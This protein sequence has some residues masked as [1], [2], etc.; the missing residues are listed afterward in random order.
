MVRRALGSLPPTAL[1]SARQQLHQ[2]AQVL[3]AAG[4]SYLP[5]LPDTSHTAM[6]W[7]TG[8][9]ALV[10]FPLPG[11]R[12]CRIALRAADLTLLLLDEGGRARAELALPGR[13]RAE[14]EAWTSAQVKAHS[15]GELDRSLVHPGF[16]LEPHPL[17]QGGR[18]RIEAGLAEL[19]LWYSAADEELDRIARS[20]PGAGPVL[21]WPHHFDLATLI[22]VERDAGGDALRTIGVGLSPG[23]D[24]FDEPYWYVNHDPSAEA[25]ALPPLPAGGWTT[26]YWVGAVLRGSELVAAGGAE[27]QAQR[28]RD[29]LDAAL[30]ASQALVRQAPLE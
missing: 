7:D 2:A 25:D 5:P 3:A 19:A 9:G 12:P 10:G 30:A 28:Q 14:A 1:I 23:D 20:T 21:C 4:E 29:F 6:T 24:F 18:F 27:G 13:T 8:L 17:A 15:G 16:E 26:E 22:A 11:P